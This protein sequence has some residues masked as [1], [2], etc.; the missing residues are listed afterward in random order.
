MPKRKHWNKFRR[1]KR[2]KI[3][4]FIENRPHGHAHT[5]ATVIIWN[6]HAMN[7]NWTENMAQRCIFSRVEN[8]VQHIF[9]LSSSYFPVSIN[10]IL[11]KK[12][13]W[14]YLQIKFWIFANRVFSTCMNDSFF[15]LNGHLTNRYEIWCFVKDM[16]R[17]FFL[18]ETSL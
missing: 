1:N 12:N 3:K 16:Y 15:H 13:Y 5:L 9:K 18:K 7:R 8:F 10:K 6:R 14:L 4:W 17:L 2:G 11:I